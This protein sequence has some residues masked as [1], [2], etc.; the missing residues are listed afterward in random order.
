[1]ASGSELKLYRSTKDI[2]WFAFS[3]IIGWVMFPAEIGG[4]QKRR[5]TSCILLLD[6]REVPLKMGFNTGLPGAPKSAAGALGRPASE[7][8]P[9]APHKRN[10]A[11]IVCLTCN[12][13]GCV[14]RCRFQSVEGP[15]FL[16]SA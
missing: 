16:K 4:W 13:K 2:R 14:G 9:A 3:P 11:K 12:L 7:V 10:K 6:M 5:R 15:P 8:R 1:M